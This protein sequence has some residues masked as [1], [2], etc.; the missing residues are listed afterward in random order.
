MRSQT[1]K[2]S[3]ASAVMQSPAFRSRLLAVG[4][5]AVFMQL[6]NCCKAVKNLGVLGTCKAVSG[7]IYSDYG[8]SGSGNVVSVTA[9]D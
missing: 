6:A 8:T 9:L 5:Q 4:Q 1:E 2:F 7:K 3:S